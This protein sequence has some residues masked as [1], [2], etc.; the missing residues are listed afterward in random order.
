VIEVNGRLGGDLIP[1]LGQLSGAGSAGAIA[2]T[3]ASGRRPETTSGATERA[4]GVQFVYPE[5]D[6]VFEGLR[7]NPEIADEPWLEEVRMLGTPGT[8]VRLPPH[9]FLSRVACSVVTADDLPQLILRM[10][11]VATGVRATG[12]SLKPA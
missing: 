9:G 12:T 11:A 6:M 1:Y 2:A 3:V 5:H 10:D 4:V 7:I 8:E